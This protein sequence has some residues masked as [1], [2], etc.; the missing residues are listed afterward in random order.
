MCC[1]LRI[2]SGI[3]IFFL[4]SSGATFVH[5]FSPPFFFLF[6]N[7]LDLYVRLSG[8]SSSACVEKSEE[9]KRRSGGRARRA[10]EREVLSCHSFLLVLFSRAFPR[11]WPFHPNKEPHD[12]KIFPNGERCRRT[13]SKRSDLV[14]ENFP[15]HAWFLSATCDHRCDRSS[16]EMQVSSR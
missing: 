13:Y 11:I 4:L 5:S 16:N 3:F 6:P 2:N 9:G 10:G 15:N 8:S 14:A 1:A 7:L 12:L